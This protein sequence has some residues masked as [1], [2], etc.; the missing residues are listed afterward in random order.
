MLENPDAEHV[1]E[2]SEEVF[3]KTEAEATQKCQNIANSRTSNDALVT[4]QG[5]P[6][7]K[8]T[9]KNKQGGYTWVCKFRVEAPKP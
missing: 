6:Q 4:V 9:T 3:A 2:E 8:T 7:Q 5:K 1:S